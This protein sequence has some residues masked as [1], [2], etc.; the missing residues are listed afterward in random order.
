MLGGRKNEELSL[1]QAVI[2]Q[3]QTIKM[4][5]LQPLFFKQFVTACCTKSM[6]ICE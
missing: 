2:K 3:M 4:E 1:T 6:I 5:L